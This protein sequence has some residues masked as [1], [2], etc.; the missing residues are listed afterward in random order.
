MKKKLI[1]RYLSQ[2]G[3]L[4]PKFTYNRIFERL[5]EPFGKRDKKSNLGNV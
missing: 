2:V 1:L 5:F 4:V 3:Y